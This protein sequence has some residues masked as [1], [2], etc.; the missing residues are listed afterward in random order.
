MIISF[1]LPLFF[2][3]LLQSNTRNT[4][5][6]TLGGERRRSFCEKH[7]WS[8]ANN[9]YNVATGRWPILL[10]TH[11][12]SECFWEKEHLIASKPKKLMKTANRILKLFTVKWPLEHRWPLAAVSTDNW[13]AH[14]LSKNLLIITQKFWHSERA[15]EENSLLLCQE[16]SQCTGNAQCGFKQRYFLWIPVELLDIKIF[17]WLY[18]PD[19]TSLV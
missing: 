12:F 15:E 10:K 13:F 18:C 17:P 9:H 7:F 2:A 5:R 16:R 8:C 11:I 4:K 6:Q 19:L 1:V 14:F 3:A